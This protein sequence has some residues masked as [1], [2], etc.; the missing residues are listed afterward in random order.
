MSE[1]KDTII[2]LPKIPQGRY[3]EDFVAAELCAYGFY[4]ERSI[5]QREPTQILEL[6]IV[7]TKFTP[8]NMTKTICEVKSGGW[9]IS[10]VFKVKGW[11]D[12]LKYNR[13]LFVTLNSGDKIDYDILKEVA[14]KIAIDLVDLTITEEKSEID[15]LK[16]VDGVVSLDPFLHKCIVSVLRFAYALERNFVN[17]ARDLSKSQD[18]QSYVDI[19][20]FIY[21]VNQHSFFQE[22]STARIT[23]IFEAYIKYK[24]LT[25][26]TDTERL[27]NH[28]IADADAVMLSKDSYSELYYRVD[29]Q[30]TPLHIA[31]YAELVCRLTILRLCVEETSRL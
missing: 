12:Y 13:G 17:Y 24:N 1:T 21:I 25:A 20:D 16:Q 3:Y 28:Y 14:S 5:E 15:P 22:N 31:Q 8:D 10:D 4:I 6:D 11:L 30:K 7:I 27:T 9:G 19:N 29:P 23:E 26:K 2:N 18:L